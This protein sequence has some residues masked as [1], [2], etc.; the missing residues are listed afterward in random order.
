MIMWILRQQDLSSAEVAEQLICQ[1]APK[2]FLPGEVDTSKLLLEIWHI[3]IKSLELLLM[4]Q[5]YD[6]D[7]VYAFS[8]DGWILQWCQIHKHK[9]KKKTHP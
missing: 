6:L 5:E 7:C 8:A 1:N 4:I 9:K 3:F 2:S